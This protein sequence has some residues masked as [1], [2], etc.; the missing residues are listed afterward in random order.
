MSYKSILEIQ[1]LVKKR[2]SMKTNIGQKPMIFVDAQFLSGPYFCRVFFS[3]ADLTFV[4]YWSK[5]RF[6]TT[7]P[8]DHDALGN[9]NPDPFNSWYTH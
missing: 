1:G 8:G 6:V 2:K 9:G 4:E 7:K 3:W 5:S